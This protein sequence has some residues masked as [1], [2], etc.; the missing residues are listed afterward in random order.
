MNGCVLEEDGAHQGELRLHQLR[1]NGYMDTEGAKS[2]V[3]LADHGG[4]THN[5]A[6]LFL[7]ERHTS[8]TLHNFS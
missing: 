6:E 1:R 3:E 4:Q 2:M 5:Y 7:Q 8:C